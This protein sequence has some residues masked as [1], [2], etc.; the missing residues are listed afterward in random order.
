MA[1]FRVKNLIE[2]HNP[3]SITLALAAV[4]RGFGKT[5]DNRGLY[6]GSSQSGSVDRSRAGCFVVGGVA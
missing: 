6:K 4:K 1:L 5:T 2:E 3:N